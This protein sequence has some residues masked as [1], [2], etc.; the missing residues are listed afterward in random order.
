MIDF[1]IKSLS[2]IITAFIL[3]PHGIFAEETESTYISVN[4][5]AFEMEDR[6]GIYTWE[7]DVTGFDKEDLGVEIG[8]EEITISAQHAQ[9]LPAEP[10]P[11]AS[12]RS[13]SHLS[14]KEIF[15]IPEDADRER[16][17]TDVQNNTLTVKIPKKQ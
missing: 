4:D 15:S 3:I 1:K 14:F 10:D 5:T 17:S 9:I 12:W 16:I 8:N 6:D 11:N 7:V 13:E 2:L